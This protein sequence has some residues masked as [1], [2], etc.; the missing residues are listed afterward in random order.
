MARTPRGSW[1]GCARFG[2]RDAFEDAR[3]LP[4][5]PREAIEELNDT[6]RELEVTTYR[7]R[8]ITREPGTAV[9]TSSFVISLVTGEE[10][11]LDM[12]MDG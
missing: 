6:L 7:V 9:G 12:R 1:K 8:S 4:E 10:P 3:N 2:L 5:I 11:P